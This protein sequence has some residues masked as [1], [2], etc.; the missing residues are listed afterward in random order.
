LP[1][2]R[3]H[4]FLIQGSAIRKGQGAVAGDR[5]FKQKLFSL[6]TTDA[7]SGL[8]TS[9]LNFSGVGARMFRSMW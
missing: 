6:M 2:G 3:T 4:I 8:G 5:T 1:T 9:K 7:L